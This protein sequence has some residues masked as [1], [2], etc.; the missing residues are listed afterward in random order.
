MLSQ[1]PGQQRPQPVHS[2]HRLPLLDVGPGQ[3]AVRCTLRRIERQRP[4]RIGSCLGMFAQPSGNG[5]L[6]RKGRCRLRIEP[7]RLRKAFRRPVQ[8]TAG[9]QH[10]RPPEPRR[11]IA[12]VLMDHAVESPHRLRQPPF[13][14]QHLTARRQQV[15]IVRGERDGPVN[16]GMGPGIIRCLFPRPGRK[17]QQHR[18]N[19]P[20][21]Q[22]RLRQ[23]RRAHY[24]ARAKRSINGSL[25]GSQHH[26]CLLQRTTRR[27]YWA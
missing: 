10:H 9:L 5:R 26:A 7:R 1:F 23:P 2:A 16:Q 19:L 24:V 3:C 21:R 20:P 4:R 13:L 14:Q 8:R 15:H 27:G 6:P 22:R 11:R 17:V 12:G 18:R 25:G